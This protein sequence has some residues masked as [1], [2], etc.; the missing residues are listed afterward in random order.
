VPEGD[1][2]FRSA[3]TLHRALAG[4]TVKRFE[5]GVATLASFND[6]TPVAGRTIE[7]VESRGKWLIIHFSGDLMLVTH[8][9]MSGSW[10]IYRPRERWRMPR[11]AMRAVIATDAFEAVAFNVPIVQFHNASSLARSPAVPK[12]GPDL[13]GNDFSAEDARSRLVARGDDEVGNALLNQRVMAGIGNVYKSEI[14]FACGVNPFRKVVTLSMREVDCILDTA[15]KFLADNVKDGSSGK[16]VTY[17]GPR[18]TTQAA[19]PGERMWVY[20]RRGKECRRCG[21]RV[22][23]QKQGVGA[24]STFW[25]PECQ[26]AGDQ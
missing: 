11:T 9:L 1:T 2:I 13:L 6:D 26:P 17:T 21:A 7:R 19:N 23:M 25:C 24:R 20:R 12:L 5:T 16:M 8:M 22:Q 14:C 15:R 18:R 3:R 4:S 10:H